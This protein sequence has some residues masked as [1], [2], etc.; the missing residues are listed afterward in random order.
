MEFFKHYQQAKNSIIN[1]LIN[2]IKLIC[3]ESQHSQISLV[4]ISHEKEIAIT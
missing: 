4:L 2:E 3:N 1:S